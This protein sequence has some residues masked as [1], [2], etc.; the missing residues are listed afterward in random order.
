M[1]QTRI[2][3]M[4]EVVSRTGLSRSTI[5]Q[6]ISEGTFPAQ[7]KLGERSVGWSSIEV[8][9]WIEVTLSKAGA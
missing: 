3:R 2:L 6:R 8:D 9:R 7:V 5:Y 1:N 4:P